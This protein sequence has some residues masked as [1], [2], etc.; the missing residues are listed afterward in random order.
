MESQKMFS[1]LKRMYESKIE[2]T[3]ESERF[4]EL[5][6]YALDYAH[7]IGLFQKT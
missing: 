6:E 5:S 7:A 2:Q 4:E 3:K 1:T